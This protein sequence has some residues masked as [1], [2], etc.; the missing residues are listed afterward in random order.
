MNDPSSPAKSGHYHADDSL[1]RLGVSRYDQVSSMLIS[2]L[3]ILGL[4]VSIMFMIWLTT[5]IFTTQV[6]VPLDMVEIG[7]QED[8][9]IGPGDDIEPP[10]PMETDLIEEPLDEIIDAVEDA[11]AT[12]A[13]MLERGVSGEGTGKGGG[14]TG[15]GRKGKPRRWELRFKEGNTLDAYA[16]QLDYFKIELGVLIPGNKVLYISNLS[17]SRPKTRKG[18]RNKEKRYRF[19]WTQGSLEEADRLLLGRANIDVGRG[20]IYK[21]LQPELTQKLLRLE[22]ESAGDKK[23]KTTIFGIKPDGSGH[24]FYVIRQTYRN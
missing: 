18:P 17:Q 12:K 24:Q 16:R 21:F 2:L 10:P 4:L 15:R 11:M 14:G 19:T 3:I 22:K 7:D 6:A 13:A 8:D 20:L 9:P 23:V 1:Y 5:Q